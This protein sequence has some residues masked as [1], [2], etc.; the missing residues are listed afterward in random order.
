VNELHVRAMTRPEYDEFLARQIPQYAQAHIRAGTWTPDEAERMAADQFRQ[1]LPDG[2]DTRDT[3][4]RTAETPDG[5][6]VGLIWI[7]L[8]RPGAPPGSAW[9]FDIEVDPAR[10][11]EGWGRALLRA[12][13]QDAARHG[14]TSIALNVFGDNTT[15]RH[16]YDTSGYETAALTLRKDLPAPQ[17]AS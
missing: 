9:I 11:G 17:D 15:A 13:E 10:R 7:A 2:P 4:L 5:H 1:L 8:N 3:L 14:A 6:R 16:L 12:G